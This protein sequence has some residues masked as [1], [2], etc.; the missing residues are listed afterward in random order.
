VLSG[1]GGD[2][3]CAICQ[4]QGRMFSAQM[5][6]GLDG[7]TRANLGSGGRCTFPGNGLGRGDFGLTGESYGPAEDPLLLERAPRGER[8][9]GR[10]GGSP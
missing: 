10:R 2:I 7:K 8:R 5:H 3:S 1:H 9:A 4:G 6:C